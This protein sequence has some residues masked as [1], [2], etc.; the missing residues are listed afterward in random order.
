MKNKLGNLIKEKREKKGISKI[1]LAKKIDINKSSMYRIENGEFK[2]PSIEILLS[3]SNE[4]DIPFDKLLLLAGYEVT[5]YKKI[6][7]KLFFVND[8]VIE[9]N[10]KIYDKVISVIDGN[11]IIDIEKVLNCYKNNEIDLQ[12]TIKLINNCNPIDLNDNII[13]Q[14]ENGNIIIS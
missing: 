9:L 5:K 14:T 7:I 12:T 10:D 13:Y 6:F 3:L 11:E 4:L 1:E 8:I 2:K